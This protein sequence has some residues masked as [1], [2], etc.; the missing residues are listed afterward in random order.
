[1]R[2]I[3]EH[4]GSDQDR[5]RKNERRGEL[6]R[7]FIYESASSAQEPTSSG[8]ADS[9]FIAGGTTIIDLMKLE[10]MKPSRLVDLNPLQMRGI[11]MSEDGLRIGALEK[12]SVVAICP[13]VAAN[14]RAL[15]RRFAIWRASEETCCNEPAVVISET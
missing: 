13:E 15:R 11:E 5:G 7:P 10:V 12:M 14:S 6:M 2:R 3:P 9:A 1:V 8:V 4:R